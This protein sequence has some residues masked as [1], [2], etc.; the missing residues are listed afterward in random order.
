MT[1][2]L[3]PAVATRPTVP[4]TIGV[5]PGQRW[6]GLAVRIDGRCLDATILD[7][8]P[9]TRER[10]RYLGQQETKLATRLLDTVAL[11]MDRHH[12][13]AAEA[14]RCWQADWPEGMP[15]RI[16]VEG[17]VPTCYGNPARSEER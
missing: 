13:Q 17:I 2:T 9:T 4:P 16:A 10:G 8:G 1:A 11:L 3:S 7:R 6:V 12:D 15:W 14:S 5:D